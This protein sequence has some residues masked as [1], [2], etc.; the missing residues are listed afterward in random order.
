MC[1][2]PKILREKILALEEPLPIVLLG[3]SQAGVYRVNNKFRYRILM[4]C[5]NTRRFRCLLRE[6]F[7]AA[8]EQ[9][10]LGRIT[11]FVDINGEIL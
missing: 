2:T 8:S 7:A 11:V 9:K 5:R 1:G 3:V 10:L 4:K 6:A